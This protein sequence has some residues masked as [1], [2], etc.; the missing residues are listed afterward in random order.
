MHLKTQFILVSLLG[1]LSSVAIIGTVSYIKAKKNIEQAVGISF[2]AA[3]H[4]TAKLADYVRQQT[5]VAVDQLSR[6]RVMEDVLTGDR[7]GALQAYLMNFVRV[8]TTFVRVAAINRN[9]EIIASSDLDEAGDRFADHALVKQ[10]LTGQPH[11]DDVHFDERSQTWV[12]TITYPIPAQYDARQVIGV[13]C[14]QWRVTQLSELL[15]LELGKESAKQPMEVMMLRKD[16]LLIA[17]SYLPR[18]W[19]FHYNLRSE[20]VSSAIIA[21]ERKRGYLQERDPD[22]RQMLVGYDFSGGD[23]DSSAIEWTVLVRQDAATVFAP[24]RRLWDWVIIVAVGVT[25][26]VLMLSALVSHRLSV[27]IV[28]IAT[29]VERVARGDFDGHVQRQSSDEVGTLARS[30]NQMIDDLK[31][32]RAQL[33]Q[34]NEELGQ[35]NEQLKTAQTSLMH[36][37]KMET[38]GRLAAGVAHEVKNPLAVITLGIEYLATDF[39]DNGDR[40]VPVVLKEMLESTVRADSIIRG[41]LDFS[42]SNR[43]EMIKEDLNSAIEQSLQLVRHEL[44][45]NRITVDKH[46]DGNLPHLKLNRTKMEQVFINLFINAVHAMPDGGILSVR[47]YTQQLRTKD[48]GSENSVATVV[49][50]VADTGTGIPPGALSK[51]FEPFFT[52]KA[53]GVGTGLG[54]SVVKNIIELHGGTITMANRAEGGAQA[55]LTFKAE[56]GVLNYEQETHLVG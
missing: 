40:N 46:L 24:I 19:L 13:V 43:L 35:S 12:D 55:T 52:T 36:S 1:G 33:L 42:A 51:V 27:P 50:E 15:E 31:S 29:V 14:A 17:S 18:S 9:G 37:Y 8:N 3:A 47:T 56:K 25:L 54:L 32:Q 7:V 53:A 44:M 28:E 16:G 21:P 23:K 39:P 22:G 4:N 20:G 48:D 49:V 41:L 34:M 38:V 10:V 11:F 6:M 2:Q 30:F 5:H 26:G 45:R